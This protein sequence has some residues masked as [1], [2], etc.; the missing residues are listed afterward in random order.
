M[1][2]V[3]MQKL[4]DDD[5]VEG[6]HAGNVIFFEA[7]YSRYASKLYA[8]A[9]NILRNK[10]VCEDLIQELFIDLWTKRNQLLISKLNAYLYTSVR[11]KSLMVLRSGRITLDLEVI[12]MLVDDY[13]TD[14]LV[15]QNEIK[16]SLE[17]EVSALPPKCREIFVLSRK[18][19][20]SHKEI[21]SLL[22]IS[23]KTVENQI[24]TALKRLKA[25]MVDF[26]VLMLLLF[27]LS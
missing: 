22:N 2:Q 25:S 20:L 12:S 9:Y 5:L 26:L 1:N 13:A 23:V 11:N 18:E 3:D 7:I 24:N 14:D 27:L 16:E 10:E 21:G 6:L 17:R 4:S 8:A 19:Q 15:I